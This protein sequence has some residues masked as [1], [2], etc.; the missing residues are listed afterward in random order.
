MYLLSYHCCCVA[1]DVDVEVLDWVVLEE[2]YLE[3]LGEMKVDPCYHQHLQYYQRKQ[4]LLVIEKQPSH[5]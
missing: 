1:C 5:L 3:P 4:L 2:Q